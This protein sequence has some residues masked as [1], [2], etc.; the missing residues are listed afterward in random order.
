M[1]DVVVD[2]A[3]SVVAEAAGDVDVLA[4]ALTQQ[5]LQRRGCASVSEA[6]AGAVCDAAEVCEMQQHSSRNNMQ[7]H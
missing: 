6:A 7:R 5:L 4:D 3:V 2:W 1:L